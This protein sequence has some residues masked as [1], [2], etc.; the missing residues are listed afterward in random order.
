[1]RAVLVLFIPPKLPFPRSERVGGAQTRRNR[2][3]S[4]IALSLKIFTDMFFIYAAWYLKAGHDA[5][6]ETQQPHGTKPS[7]WKTDPL[8]FVFYMS[9]HSLDF[10][11]T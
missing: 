10:S 7:L 8:G 1:M 5:R 4:P 3:Y 6:M 2:V 9:E 11:M